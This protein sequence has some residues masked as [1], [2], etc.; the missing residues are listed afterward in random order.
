MY[1]LQRQPSTSFWG[2]RRPNIGLFAGDALV[3]HVEPDS[4]IS[5]QSRV[6]L[7]EE[8]PKWAMAFVMWL[9]VLI[10]RREMGEVS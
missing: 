7:P 4:W 1:R 10:W 3:G 2:W 5:Y 8:M 6:S 9:T